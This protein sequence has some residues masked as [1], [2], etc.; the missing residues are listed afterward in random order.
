MN[1]LY[2]EKQLNELRVQEERLTKDYNK[3][4]EKIKTEV[5]DLSHNRSLIMSNYDLNKILNAK[6]FIYTEGV[7]ENFRGDASIQLSKAINDVTNDF[8]ILR[9]QYIGCKDYDQWRCQGVDC[10]YGYCPSHG[11]VVFRIGMKER[12]ERWD[13]CHSKISDSEISDS[14]KSD[15]LCFLNL[16]TDKKSRDE[17]LKV[18]E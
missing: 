4:L 6:R 1:L 12:I 15:I 13:I 8:K 2:I 9:K 3:V 11:S 16:L 17:I 14:D 10:E 5:S 18:G 7:K